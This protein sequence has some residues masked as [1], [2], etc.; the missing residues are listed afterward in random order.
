MSA[1]S[2]YATPSALA[3]PASTGQAYSTPRYQRPHGVVSPRD[4]SQ[5]ILVLG[6]TGYQYDMTLS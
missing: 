3:G 6:T 2:P 5:D 4:S 1:G